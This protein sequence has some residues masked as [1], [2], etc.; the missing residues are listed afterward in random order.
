MTQKAFG[1]DVM[2]AMH[3][4]IWHKHFK[5]GREPVESDLCFPEEKI[6]QELHSG[7]PSTSTPENVACVWAAINKDW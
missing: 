6:F 5:N 2:N 4:K 7:R 3:I 1:D